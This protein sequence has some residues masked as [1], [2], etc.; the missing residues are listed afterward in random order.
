[1]GKKHTYIVELGASLGLDLEGD[2]ICHVQRAQ[3]RNAGTK[4][5]D[6]YI[7][8]LGKERSMYTSIVYALVV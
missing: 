2:D 8:I 3:S 7:N 4:G 1:M 5:N 6:L